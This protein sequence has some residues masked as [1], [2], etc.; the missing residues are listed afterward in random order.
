MSFDG[1][2][3][4]K[5]RALART[6]VRFDELR[7]RFYD[8][9]TKRALPGLTQR[10]AALVP[11]PFDKLPARAEERHN[12]SCRHATPQ[13][14]CSCGIEKSTHRYAGRTM[15]RCTTCR[16]AI[17][18]AR[19]QPGAF[20]DA[21]RAERNDDKVH[22]CA[23]DRQLTIYVRDGRAALFEQ[24]TNAVDPCV[25]TLLEH[26]D[27]RRTAAVASQVPL[28][29][30]SLHAATAADLLL[31][32]RATRKKLILVEIK[33]SRGRDNALRADAQYERVRGTLR[34]TDLRGCPLSYYAR[35]QLQLY[36]MHRIAREAHGVR[37][38]DAVIV[39]VAPG[40]VREYAHNRLYE[41]RA[42]AVARALSTHP[43]VNRRR[44]QRSEVSADQRV[45][46]HKP[47]TEKDYLK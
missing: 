20:G 42:T 21:M 26:F 7:Q 30:G 17:A 47:N 5:L 23:V 25:G 8:R 24:C 2:L 16:H 40:I 12:A 46:R 31:T 45:K 11:V 44:R 10:L 1:E 6:D 18:W 4:C 19:A 43:L 37:F 27:A 28:Y 41:R 32:D 36:C 38:D 39:R 15:A 35:H 29:S 34:R 14:H 9:R 13:A 33:A 3:Q 22:G